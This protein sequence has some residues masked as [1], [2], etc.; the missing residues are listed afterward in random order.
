MK[1]LNCL[2]ILVL[3]LVGC[4]P[5]EN[6]SLTAFPTNTTVPTQVF[7]PTTAP[8]SEEMTDSK[9]VVMR[10]ISAGEFT[11]G[12]G[13]ANHPDNSDERPAHKVYLDTFYIDKYEVTNKLYKAC[14]DAGTCQPPLGSESYTRS[15]YYDNPQFDHYPVIL[16]GWDMAKT[17]CEWRGAQL[18]TEAQWEKAA[19]GTDARTYPW[20]EGIDCSKARYQGGCKDD[21]AQVGSYE[22]GVSPYG[23][24]DM[25]GNVMEWVADWYSETYY[26]N[27]PTSNPLGPD[28]GSGENRVLRGGSWISVDNDVRSTSRNWP[29]NSFGRGPHASVE[30]GFR[31]ARGISP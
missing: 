22:S 20:G 6:A 3:I 30:I 1:A 14:V 5:A 18:P 12:S 28:S 11:M 15:S 24:Y 31:C 26:Q 21:T 7:T 2:F 4:A 17:Y 25:A 23:V 9:G 16:V 10:F 13:E 8:L 29:W 27:S 19:R